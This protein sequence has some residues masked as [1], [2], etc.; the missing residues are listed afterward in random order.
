MKKALTIR[1]ASLCLAAVAPTALGCLAPDAGSGD[2]LPDGFSIYEGSVDK[3]AAIRGWLRADALTNDFTLYA[4]SAFDCPG[5]SRGTSCR[6]GKVAL[7]EEMQPYAAEIVQRIGD[8][9]IVLD[10]VVSSGVS[11][12]E[13]VLNF[14]RPS[15]VI[16]NAYR[17]MFAGG[18]PKLEQWLGQP[19]V[20]IAHGVASRGTDDHF[21]ING[22]RVKCEGTP[23]NGYIIDDY[24]DWERAQRV[25]AGA[26]ALE[27]A[28]T[29]ILATFT[30]SY[31]IGR[32]V[33]SPDQVYSPISDVVIG[34]L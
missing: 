7:S 33:I 27:T 18:A 4:F 5:A 14:E 8:D 31:W 12:S 23:R 9:S 26:F 16:T 10:V 24:G 21:F 11:T 29:E 17:G 19:D 6:L 2:E 22:S 13:G 32:C 30:P 3:S 34:S 15:I 20:W 1:L 25:L 28:P